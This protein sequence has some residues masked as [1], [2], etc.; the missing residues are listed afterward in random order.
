MTAAGWSEEEKRRR[1]EKRRSRSRR[2]EGERDATM[3]RH[4][5]DQ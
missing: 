3:D 4:W 5:I 2:G 1:G